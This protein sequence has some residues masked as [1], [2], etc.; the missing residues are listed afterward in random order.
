MC[1]PEWRLKAALFPELETPTD[2][3]IEV[4][5]WGDVSC[6]K[7][8]RSLDLVL[9]QLPPRHF[10]VEKTEDVFLSQAS[11]MQWACEWLEEG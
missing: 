1:T 11:M 9:P 2:A 7:Q 6:A 3:V 5:S 10:P 8:R 4:N